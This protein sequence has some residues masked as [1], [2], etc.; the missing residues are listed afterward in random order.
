M[1]ILQVNDVKYIYKSKYQTVQALSGVSC[2]FERGSVY[3]IIGSSGCGK[4]TL[5]SLLSG[6]DLPFEGTISYSGVSTSEID[7]DL[8]R[9]NDV[10]VI[11][12][13]FNLFPLLTGLENV[14]YPMELLK[15]KKPT[16]L[17]KAKQLI[18][19]VGLTEKVY[20]QYPKMMSGG[21]QQRIAIAR[22]LASNASIIL[23]DEPTGNLDSKNGQNIMDILKSLAHDNDYCVI[24]VTHDDK[25]ASQADYIIKMSDGLIVSE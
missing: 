22:A 24:I 3:A 5:L 12:Q 23:A 17:S 15:T 2:E 1:A 9:R 14:L 25:I 20:K 10:T 7:R 11:Y 13:A 8:Y 6:L 4:T 16:A 18:S 19:S 21:E